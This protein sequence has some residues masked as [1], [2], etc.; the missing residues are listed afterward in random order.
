MAH[1]PQMIVTDNGRTF[2]SLEF[3]KF[4]QSQGIVH[5]FTAPY[6]PATNGQAERFIQTLKQALKRTHCD[7]SNLDVVLSR[8][9]LQYR[10]TPH[11]TTNKSPAEI[12]LNRKLRTRLDLIIPSEQTENIASNPQACKYF[13]CG[14]RVACRNYTKDSKW[15]FGTITNKLGKLHYKIALDDGRSW[16]RHIN[17]MRFIGKNTPIVNDDTKNTD[18]WEMEG[19]SDEGENNENIL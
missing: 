12:F 8:I 7:S 16:I 10:I 3:K 9:L 2:T 1:I 5:K 6:N 14:E 18:Y 19:S 4:L 17:Q 11:A 13:I 15:K